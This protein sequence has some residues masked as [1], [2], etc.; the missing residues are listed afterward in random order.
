MF[1][2]I[3]IWLEFNRNRILNNQSCSLLY[4]ILLFIII[5]LLIIYIPYKE[6]CD[7]IKNYKE[8]RKEYI[9]SYKKFKEMKNWK[10]YTYQ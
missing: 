10:I 3:K 6:L 7:D 5:P 1:K 4:N 8:Q 9:N 2:K